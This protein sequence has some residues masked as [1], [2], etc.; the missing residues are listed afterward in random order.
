[1][2]PLGN[3]TA[4]VVLPHDVGV[5]VVVEVASSNSVPA[6]EIRELE[7]TGDLAVGHEPAAFDAM[8]IVPNDVGVAV[9]VEIACGN[10]VPARIPACHV[11]VAGCGQRELIPGTPV[12]AVEG[13]HPHRLGTVHLAAAH[14]H[15]VEV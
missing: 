12:A 9:V 2:S 15:I 13:A 5:A 6:R 11:H 10:R 7:G 8:S 4:V 1:M 3:P 14:P